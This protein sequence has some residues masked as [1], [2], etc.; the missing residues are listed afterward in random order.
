[1]LFTKRLP[2]FTSPIGLTLKSQF[3]WSK[4]PIRKQKPR[5]RDF[6]QGKWGPDHGAQAQTCRSPAAKSTRFISSEGVL[7]R[8]Q[9]R[10]APCHTGRRVGNGDGPAWRMSGLQGIGVVNKEQRLAPQLISVSGIVIFPGG[11]HELMVFKIMRNCIVNFLANNTKFKAHNQK[12][13][14]NV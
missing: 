2:N 9:K 10:P 3:F 4:S 8:Q 6:A 7:P 5:K 14:Y 12:V 11:I 1:M 13:V